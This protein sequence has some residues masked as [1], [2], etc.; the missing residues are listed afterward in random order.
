MNVIFLDFDGVLCTYHCKSADDIEEKIKLLAGICQRLNCKVV[1]S[2]AHKEDI[3]ED[4]LEVKSQYASYA[5]MVLNLLKKYGI[6]VIGRTPNLKSKY[7]Y[8][9]FPKEDVEKFIS[10]YYKKLEF[11]KDSLKYGFNDYYVFIEK[12]PKLSDYYNEIMYSKVKIWKEDEIRIYLMRHPEIEHYVILD[13]DDIGPRN[14]DLKK[15]RDHLIV[16]EMSDCENP[17]MEGLLPEHEEEIAR[18]LQKE[19]KVR[20]YIL[21]MNEKRGKTR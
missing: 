3:D 7:H 14:S 10:E 5:K 13:D 2:S 19:N 9:K 20:S 4:T 17:L 16:T 1:I 21:R 6:E 8:N 12:Y 18:I 11:Y 15:V